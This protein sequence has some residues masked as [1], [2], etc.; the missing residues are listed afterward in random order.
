LEAQYEIQAL[1]RERLDRLIARNIAEM[2]RSRAKALIEAGHVKV[3]GV[4]R[5]TASAKLQAGQGVHVVVPPLEQLSLVPEDLNLEIVFEDADLLVVNKRAGMVV[6]PSKGHD[7]GTLVHGLLHCI[8]DLSGI[9]GTERP[10]IVHRL[11]KGTSGVMVVAKSD[12]AH[13]ALKDQFF[14]HSITREYW[15]LV[16]GIP[17]LNAGDVEGWLGRKDNDRMR[18]AV[19]PEGEGR[20]ARTHW[21]VVERLH[22]S[23]L[24]ACRLET[25][26]THQVRVH[27]ASKNWPLL[28]DPMYRNRQTLPPPIQ[29]LVKEVDH[30]LLHARLLAFDHP[31][32]GERL[33]F[34][35]PVPQDFQ[36]VLDGLR[37]IED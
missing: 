35:S 8:T 28:G 5:T 2:S 15:A 20:W 17:D 33:S 6:H 36:K 14:D 10:G 31:R 34:E 22:R 4:V 3:D 19:V 23:T 26:R 21:K 13:Q 29:R 1:K 32:T 11:D 16:L 25:G 18:F 30:Q 37:A 24:M 7:T 12:V 9:G 27:M